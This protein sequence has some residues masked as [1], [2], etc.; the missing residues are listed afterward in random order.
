MNLSCAAKALCGM[1]STPLPSPAQHHCILCKDGMHG[2]AFCGA[3]WQDNIVDDPT[4][5]YDIPADLFDEETKA[6]ISSTTVICH[7]C[8][9]KLPRKEATT[10]AAAT[11][12]TA[13]TTANNTAAAASTTAP[14]PNSVVFCGVV[15]DAAPPAP[16]TKKNRDDYLYSQYHVTPFPDGSGA[17]YKCRHCGDFDVKWKIPNATRLRSHSTRCSGLTD[18]IAK[19]RLE[20]GSQSNKR[21]GSQLA[22]Q[23]HPNESVTHFRARL[24]PQPSGALIDLSSSDSEEISDITTSSSTPAAKKTKIPTKKTPSTQTYLPQTYEVMKKEVAEEIIMAEVTVVLARG[25]PLSRMLDPHYQQSLNLRHPALLKFLPTNT[26]AIYDKYVV[27][28][29]EATTMDLQDF[30]KKVPGHVNVAMDGVTANG[31][32]KVSDSLFSC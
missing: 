26:A 20:A 28:I 10:T 17:R 1:K 6:K 4:S 21:K 2:A 27:K 8:I 22:L 5:P 15:S 18:P 29:D 14:P 13:S 24:G 9:Q 3:N 11:T 19:R 25:E 7:C 32:Q 12:T 31:K 23:S 16:K 30:I